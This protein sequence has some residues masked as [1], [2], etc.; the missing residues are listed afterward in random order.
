[1]WQGRRMFDLNNV[2]RG[3][4]AAVK[5]IYQRPTLDIYEF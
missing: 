2:N 3:H 1:M 5:E 4:F